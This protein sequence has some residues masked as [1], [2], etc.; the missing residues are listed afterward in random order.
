MKNHLTYEEMLHIK[1]RID[2]LVCYVNHKKYYRDIAKIILPIN[3]IE[4]L[5][6]LTQNQ[7]DALFQYLDNVASN[8]E[9]YPDDDSD[10]S[11]DEFIL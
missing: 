4:S 5:G 7:I 3:G 2:N 9:K 11:D 6:Q 8:G 10:Y 1:Y